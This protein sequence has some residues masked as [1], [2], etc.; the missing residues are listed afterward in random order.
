M[1]DQERRPARA[2]A[3]KRMKVLL[4][5]GK[6]RLT[7]HWQ[8]RSKERDFDEQDLLAVVLT[9]H[10]D[11]EGEWDAKHRNFKFRVVGR[12]TD[13][14]SFKVVVALAPA[15]LFLISGMRKEKERWQSE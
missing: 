13:G 5:E 6:T 7:T 10:I 2:Q 14:R 9:G 1:A 3:L 11:E 4:R 12:D 8:D 15:M